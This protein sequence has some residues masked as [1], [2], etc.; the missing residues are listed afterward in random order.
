MQPPVAMT[1]A[2]YE[3]NWK[4]DRIFGQK[5]QESTYYWY[6]E[7]F[8]LNLKTG[9]DT[10]LGFPVYAVGRGRVV[11][12]HRYTHANTPGSYGRHLI[13]KLDDLPLWVHYAHLADDGFI[14][15]TIN[16]AEGTRLG[17]IDKSG[18]VVGAKAHLHFSVFKKDPVGNIDRWARSRAELNEWWVDPAELFETWSNPAPPASGPITDQTYIPQLGMTVAQAREVVDGFNAIKE[19][20]NRF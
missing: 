11:Y 4:I 13:L 3:A 2:E 20:T 6:H 1:W 8:D 19:I 18:L 15:Q 16:V 9:G 5:V 14:N 12:Y 7:G 10:D 17:K